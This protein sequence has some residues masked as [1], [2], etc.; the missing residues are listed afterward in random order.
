[1]LYL[2]A[3]VISPSSYT[4]QV[5]ARY[6]AAQ[7]QPSQALFLRGDSCGLSWTQGVLLNKLPAQA[8]AWSVALTCEHAALAAI[9]FMKVVVDDAVWSLG[10][11]MHAPAGARVVVLYPW[12]Y[13]NAG[14]YEYLRGVYSP[15]LGNSRDVVV[16]LPPSYLENTLKSHANVLVMHDGQNLFNDSTSAF[17]CWHCDKTADANILAGSVEELVIVGVDNTDDR[18]DELTCECFPAPRRKTVTLCQVFV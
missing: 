4:L 8:D 13:S 11:N 6:P 9:I 17:G 5:T 7:L 16:Y 3:P 18:T 14:H 2:A 1:M 12:F 10:C 15:E